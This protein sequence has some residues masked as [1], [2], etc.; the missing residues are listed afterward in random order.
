M[1]QEAK[2]GNERRE[3]ARSFRSSAIVFFLGNMFETFLSPSPSPASD[4]KCHSPATFKCASSRSL[5]C[6][7]RLLAVRYV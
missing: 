3:L 4:G 5:R 6:V 1:G 7:A 2:H